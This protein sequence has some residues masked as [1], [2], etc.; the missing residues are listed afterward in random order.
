MTL[1][2]TLKI[3][4][5]MAQRALLRVQDGKIKAKIRGTLKRF[6]KELEEIH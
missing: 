5:G 2:E 1:A 4:I 6:K 3:F